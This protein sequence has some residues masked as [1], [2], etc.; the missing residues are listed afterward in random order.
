[1]I[2]KYAI[3]HKKQTFPLRI[4]SVNIPKGSKKMKNF[5]KENNKTIAL[6]VFYQAIVM[7]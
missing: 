4:S 5:R 7:E 1:M 2:G 3:T 6:H